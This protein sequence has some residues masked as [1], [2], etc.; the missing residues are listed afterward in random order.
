MAAHKLQVQFM[1]SPGKDSQVA[2]IVNMT[3]A[4]HFGLD[5]WIDL[6]Y[7]SFILYVPLPPRVFLHF[8]VNIAFV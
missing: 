6:G 1:V 4:L 3:L 2:G 5:K 8:C 7:G